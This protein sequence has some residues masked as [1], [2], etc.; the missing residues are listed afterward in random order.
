MG[1]RKQSEKI[2]QEEFGE[3]HESLESEE[4]GRTLDRVE[5]TFQEE[6]GKT[7]ESLECEELGRTLGRAKETYHKEFIVT[8][9]SL[10][11]E[12]FAR[13][14]FDMSLEVGEL[15]NIRNEA[16]VGREKCEC[17]NVEHG[18]VFDST[19]HSCNG[20]EEETVLEP[21]N[22]MCEDLKQAAGIDLGSKN[23]MCVGPCQEESVEREQERT[24][25]PCL[26]V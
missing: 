7:H 8:N 15:G 11:S 6:F 18:R 4:L 17:L 2:L 24:K 22:N 1:D 26:Q 9:K 20:Q 13:T 10:E 23:N 12:E 14:L 3:A 5:K 19:Q 21:N 25:V 16:K